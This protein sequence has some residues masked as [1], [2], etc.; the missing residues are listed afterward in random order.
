M[1]CTHTHAPA[2]M[3]VHE[4]PPMCT[5][6]PTAPAPP[7]LSASCWPPRPTLVLPWGNSEAWLPA[8]HEGK[9]W[10]EACEAG[11]GAGHHPCTQAWPGALGS[12]PSPPLP[13]AA[14]VHAA[15][16]PGLQ[17]SLHTHSPGSLP[18]GD[19]TEPLP[20]PLQAVPCHLPTPRRCPLPSSAGPQ[21]QDTFA[22]SH[23]CCT[24]P[25]AR[26]P[27]EPG[28]QLSGW[29][30][31]APNST[32]LASRGRDAPCGHPWGLW[33][34]SSSLERCRE[35][36]PLSPDA[37]ASNALRIGGKSPWGYRHWGRG[38]RAP[39]AELGGSET[40][41]K[42]AAWLRWLQAS[43]DNPTGARDSGVVSAA[44]RRPPPRSPQ[45]RGTEACAQLQQGAAATPSLCSPAPRSRGRLGAGPGRRGGALQSASLP[46]HGG[47]RRFLPAVAFGAG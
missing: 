25:W 21:D 37:L 3:C 11:S 34:Y 14:P 9:A 44:E 24:F 41:S 42:A 7:Q 10:A 5:C 6:T 35:P 29:V 15:C 39:G 2:N 8:G 40:G 1:H 17:E 45:S 33:P 47:R 23:H 12:S 27:P 19:H 46:Q 22:P 36:T 43:Q 28:W 20:C 18:R 30:S 26:S 13:R 31:L 32:L 16:T 4:H 38:D